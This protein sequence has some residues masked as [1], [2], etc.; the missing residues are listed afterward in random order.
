MYLEFEALMIKNEGITK[1]RDR[2]KQRH[3]CRTCVSQMIFKGCLFPLFP[4]GNTTI[5]IYI[6]LFFLS[7]RAAILF[8]YT[9][10]NLSISISNHTSNSLP[11]LASVF[12]RMTLGPLSSLKGEVSC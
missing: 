11:G 10:P 4:L 9:H 1:G 2:G 3:D 8:C 5:I 12:L 7:K 6:A